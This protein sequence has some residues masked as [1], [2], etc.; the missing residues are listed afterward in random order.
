MHF[1]IGKKKRFYVS[2]KLKSKTKVRKNNALV[3]SGPGVCYATSYYNYNKTVTVS[4]RIISQ[5]VLMCYKQSK[6]NEQWSVFW[7]S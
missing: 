1:K 6:R 2:K 4:I 3:I 7:L 5:N